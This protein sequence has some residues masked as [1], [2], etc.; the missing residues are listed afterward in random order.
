MF[1]VL[2][3]IDGTGK[4]TQTSKAV[5]RLK[6]ELGADVG[7]FAFPR[8]EETDGGA[9][10]GKYLDGSFGEVGD[11]HPKLAALTYALDRFETR[12][13][14][15][16][17]IAVREA[18][19]CDRYVPSNAAH[20]GAKLRSDERDEFFQWLFRL[21]HEIYGLPHPDMVIQLDL[22]PHMAVDLVRKKQPRAY[23][24]KAADIHEANLAYQH[25]VRG[26][27]ADVSRR[28]FAGVWKVVPVERNGHV[29]PIEDVHED[30]WS[31]VREAVRPLT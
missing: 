26:T 10:V 13:D 15:E 3:G 9:L 12:E 21:E 19:L 18:V 2:E 7:V 14:L 23:T 11:V 1:I 22:P 28:N 27:Y 24:D 29:R 4:G 25:A 17:E 8:Y 16:A 5:E 30:V 6:S 20:Q 31:L